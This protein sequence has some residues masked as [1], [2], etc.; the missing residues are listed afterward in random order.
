MSVIAVVDVHPDSFELGRILGVS[1][2]AG[3]ELDRVVPLGD[4]IIPL[5][6]V[7]GTEGEAL[8]QRV[9]KHPSVERFEVREV[10][11]DRRLIAIDW[12]ASRDLLIQGVTEVGAQVLAGTGSGSAWRFDLR[13]PDREALGEFQEFCD[14]GDID[15]EVLRINNPSQPDSG[16]WYGLSEPQREAMELAH[17][18]G[19]FEIPRRISTKELGARLGISDQ[20]VTERLRRGTSRLLDN[21]LSMGPMGD[22]LGGQV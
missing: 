8:E 22:D 20:A 16:P 3:V 10:H 11:D 7:Y 13:F 4:S 21:T 18:E 14:N 2:D 1:S 15:F 12:R 19:Y 17:R 9:M 6:W 5:V